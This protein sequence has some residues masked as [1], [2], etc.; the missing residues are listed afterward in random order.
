MEGDGRLPVPQ[1]GFPQGAIMHFRGDEE[2]RHPQGAPHPLPATPASTDIER[3][4]TSPTCVR[5]PL[6]DQ[7]SWPFGLWWNPVPS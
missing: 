3:P 6:R 7:A 1:T 5:P 4:F 2:R